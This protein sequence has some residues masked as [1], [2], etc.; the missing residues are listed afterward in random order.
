MSVQLQLLILLVIIFTIRRNSY[1][2]LPSATFWTSLGHRRLPFSPGHMPS[3]LLRITLSIPNFQPFTPV[4]LHLIIATSR[5]LT[6]SACHLFTL[7]GARKQY[8]LKKCGLA[9]DL[10]RMTAH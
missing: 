5:S 10:S 9:S 2:V 1:E 7:L 4:D 3:F 8:K 6:L